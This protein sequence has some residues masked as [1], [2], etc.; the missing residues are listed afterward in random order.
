MQFFKNL[1]ARNNKDEIIEQLKRENLM[2]RRAWGAILMN[3]EYKVGDRVTYRSLG[4]ET[5]ITIN[6]IKGLYVY[7]TS[8]DG[9]KQV[10][11]IPT[12]ALN[13]VDNRG[14]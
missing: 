8:D 1:F 10:T 11:T 3:K 13:D 7:A 12:L 14:V 6:E 4:G 5:T 2:H 9:H